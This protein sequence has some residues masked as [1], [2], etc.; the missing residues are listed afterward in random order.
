MLKDSLGGNCKTALLIAASPHV[1]NRDE[2]V[3]SL[4]FGER[5]RKIQNKAKINA[6]RTK[7][8][9]I[10]ENEELKEQ[11]ERLKKNKFSKSDSK[12]LEKETEKFKL[13]IK[14]LEDSNDS[15]SQRLKQLNKAQQDTESWM[16]LKWNRNDFD[17]DRGCD[18]G[19]AVYIECKLYADA[20][21][22]VTRG[23]EINPENIVLHKRLKQINAVL[24]KEL[25]A[26][27][28]EIDCNHLE[29]DADS[30]D[31][32][33]QQLEVLENEILSKEEELKQISG[34]VT[35][36]EEL[37]KENSDLVMKLNDAQSI[38]NEKIK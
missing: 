26:T 23:I 29:Y 12:A 32:Q 33:E 34:K 3:R 37:K 1:F 16:E 30:I 14:E 22:L 2:T 11:I 36:I 7:S 35:T 31:K 9:L 4:Q 15:L 19:S 17:F 21:K 10:K 20:K 5:C 25:A 24:S 38:L 8:Q 27:T 6:Y 18:I 13:R 28:N